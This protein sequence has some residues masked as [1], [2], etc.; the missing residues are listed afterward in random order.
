MGFFGRQFRKAWPLS[1]SCR[2]V[3]SLKRRYF[4]VGVGVLAAGLV[5][6]ALLAKMFYTWERDLAQA[7]FN[8]DAKERIEVIRQVFSDHIEIVDAM[9]AF[10]RGSQRVDP[11][12]FSTFTTPYI[13]KYPDIVALGW[14]PRIAAEQKDDHEKAMRKE[15]RGDYHIFGRD[16]Q[17]QAVPVKTSEEYFPVDFI[18]PWPKQQSL[19]GL[20]MGSYPSCRNAIDRATAA[21]Q[22]IAIPCPL[23]NKKEQAGRLLLVLHPAANEPGNDSE[24]SSATPQ[25]R[26]FVFAVLRMDPILEKSL[27]GLSEEGIDTIITYADENGSPTVLCD[28]YCDEHRKESGSQTSSC[29]ESCREREIRAQGSFDVAGLSLNVECV[30]MDS[31]LAQYFTWQPAIV[32]VGGLAFTG[33]FAAYALSLIGRAARGE[34]L[35]VERTEKLTASE[36]RFRQLLDNAGDAIFIHDQHGAILDVNQRA[37]DSLGYTRQELLSMKIEDIDIHVHPGELK[38]YWTMPEDH[39]PVGFG[40]IHRRKDGTTFPVEIRLTMM[41][42]EGKPVLL[43]LAR[44]IIERMKLI[45]TL[46]E[47]EQTLRAILDQTFQFIGLLTPEGIV[48]AINKTALAFSGVSEE[49]VVRKPF[50]ETPWWTHS[51]VLQEELRHAV[52]RAAAGE[53]IRM[54]TTHLAA[55]GDLHWIDFSL[56]PVKDENG[57]VMFLIP[58][59]RDITDRKRAEESIH[60]EQRLLREMLELQE[61]ERRLVAFEI[62]DGLAQQLTG[63]LFKF[64]VA[65][66]QIKTDVETAKKTCLEGTALLREAMAESR[67]LIGGLR[68]PMLDE[69]G[70]VT[71]IEYLV[72][73]RRRATGMDIEFINNTAFNRLVP[74]IENAIFRIVQECLTNACRYSQSEKVRVELRQRENHIFIDVQ[75]WG[76]GFDA[77]QIDPNR[78]GLRGI[79]ERARLLGGA[80][81]IDTGPK[82]GTHVK[83]ELPMVVQGENGNRM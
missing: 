17:Q 60:K 73:E 62:H 33:L 18:E 19:V 57:K 79:R 74:P 63:A 11:Q 20:D 53:F 22:K 52:A 76:I 56:K 61:R 72:D 45:R 7:E 9:A 31:Y 35:V 54:E 5:L 34:K 82:K 8:V 48:T 29:P 4:A 69:S 26:G 67:R 42:F 10:Y 64:D 38:R 2:S 3:V 75:D 37:C 49:D 65:K 44:N 77:E 24:S 40:G 13:D 27:R 51:P 41:E 46:Q 50:W 68:P 43:A 78:F 30:P 6:S 28:H 25:T 70:V 71:A 39:Y 14:A 1:F 66:E 32:F 36:W 55:N 23:L 21:N 81:V 12:E 83:V 47:S 80:V 16:R 58:E 59:G 15:G